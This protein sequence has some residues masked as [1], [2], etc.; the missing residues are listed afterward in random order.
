MVII[1]GR[2]FYRQLYRYTVLWPIAILGKFDIQRYHKQWAVMITAY[3]IIATAAAIKNY[4]DGSWG[5]PVILFNIAVLAFILGS[6]ELILIV[7]QR[8]QG[9]NAKC[10]AISRSLSYY[11][12][13]FT[14]ILM[15]QWYSYSV[16]F[17]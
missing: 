7:D 17:L 10:Q 15:C 8:Y 3:V 13:A 6:S 9:F 4:S 12:V 2:Q 14:T 1:L 16:K 5:L 11:G